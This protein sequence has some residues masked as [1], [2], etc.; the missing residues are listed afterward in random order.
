MSSARHKLSFALAS[1]TST[2][3]PCLKSSSSTYH[4]CSRPR[5]RASLCPPLVIGLNQYS[6]DASI[7]VLNA[8]TGAILF[9]LS[10]ERLSRRKHDGGDVAHLVKHALLTL[11]EMHSFE[12][13]NLLS[14]VRLV[15]ANNHHFRIA[16]Y[17]RRVRFL[18]S[19]KY[20]EETVTSE[21]NLIGTTNG[22]S[23]GTKI[24]ISHHLAHAFSAVWE[25]NM[26]RGLIVIMDGMG[27]NLNDWQN[28]LHDDHYY[29]EEK[30]GVCENTDHFREFPEDVKTRKGVSF[31]E[32]ETAYVFRKTGKHVEIRRVFKRWTPE[33][34]PSELPNHSF[35][36][37]ESVG[38]MYS[39]VS[40]I[41][42]KDWN[43]CGKVRRKKSKQL[44]IIIAPLP[45]ANYMSLLYLLPVCVVN[46][47]D[48]PRSWGSLHME[49]NGFC[50]NGN[51]ETDIL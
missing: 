34:E 5:F 41:L 3:L 47:C 1:R 46:I 18:T 9:A 50:R 23:N 51:L 17:E 42:F 45:I 11:C 30:I 31:R 2:F 40:A 44:F 48:W 16:A 4:I 19:L 13:S 38:A 36:E 28:G 20:A 22:V 26:E 10:K 43:A 37:M 25:S 49:M 15:V 14:M 8:Q 24:E 21:W 27:D 33:V 32:A 7:A 29:C 35:E 12:M 6:H 39:R